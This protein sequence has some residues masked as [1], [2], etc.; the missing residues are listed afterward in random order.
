MADHKTKGSGLNWFIRRG[1]AVRGPVSS[2]RVRHFVIEGKLGLDDEVSLDRKEWRR[3][4]TVPEVVPLQMRAHDP[5]LDA[6][7][8]DDGAGG[9]AW[10][11]MLVAGL[12][13]GAF[14]AAVYFAGSGDDAAAVD[15]GAPPEP[16]AVF[17][18]CRLTAVDWRSASL[19]GARLANA[20]LA[21]ALLTEADLSEADLRYV[22]LSGADLSYAVLAKAVLKG[23]NLRLADLTNADLRGADLSFADLSRA[24]IG[25][26]R[27]EGALLEGAVWVDGRRCDPGGCPR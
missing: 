13:I 17:D 7:D 26:A 15:C 12:V 9:K 5:A 20:S 21:D 25:G 6:V 11:T 24:R 2:T 23:A 8:V 14:T 3:I 19:R 10:I 16:A 18:G 1:S 4:G 22:D 27:F